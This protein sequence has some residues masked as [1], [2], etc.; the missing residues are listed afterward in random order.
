MAGECRRAGA[1]RVEIVTNGIPA[2]EPADYDSAAG[3]IR[4]RVAPGGE[5]IVGILGRLHPGR[6]QALLIAALAALRAKGLPLKVLLV[7]EGPA[8]A[9]YRALAAQFGV[10]EHVHFAGLS[11]TRCPI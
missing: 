1:K 9:D 11:R 7:G 8:E 6:G 4:A 10:T 5:L 3:Q 2:V